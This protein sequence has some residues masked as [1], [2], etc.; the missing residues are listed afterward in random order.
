MLEETKRMLEQSR[1]SF[2]QYLAMTNKSEEQHREEIE[3]EAR[4][5]VKRDL[6]LDTVASAENIQITDDEVAGWL[7]LYA[8]MG[9]RQLTLKNISAN[10]RANIVTRLRRD[11]ALS[12]LVEIATSDESSS[13]SETTEEPAGAEAAEVAADSGRS[14]RE[15]TA[16]TKKTRATSKAEPRVMAGEEATGKA[17]EATAP[18]TA[19]PETAAPDAT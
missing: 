12:Q 5:R 2:E 10:Q 17:A 14:E 8:A 3:P 19:A 7:E 9:G 18:E 11:K 15:T 16:K 13:S 6:V 4:E 1:L